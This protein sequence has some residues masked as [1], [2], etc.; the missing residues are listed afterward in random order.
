MTLNNTNS[1]HVLTV[2]LLWIITAICEFKNGIYDMFHVKEKHESV[3]V[4]CKI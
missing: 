2:S 4:P 3:G 1:W